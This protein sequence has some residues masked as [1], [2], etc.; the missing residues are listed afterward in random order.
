MKNR[1]TP[2]LFL[3]AFGLCTTLNTQAENGELFVSDAP[4]D[5][6]VWTQEERAKDIAIRNLQ[7]SDSLS[8][9]LVLVNGQEPPHYHDKHD[10][11]AVVLS[12]ES[13]LH[14]KDKDVRL[15]PGSIAVIPKGTFHWTENISADGSV[16]FTSFSPAFDGKDRRLVD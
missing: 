16:V 3:L 13:I 9:H 7:R 12:G 14:L 8:T 2:H 6:S 10:L 5:Y 11:T 1:L 4:V 15:S